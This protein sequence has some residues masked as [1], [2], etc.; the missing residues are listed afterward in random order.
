[1]VVPKRD[2]ANMFFYFTINPLISLQDQFT[3]I[4]IDI[5]VYTPKDQSSI[6]NINSS[7]EL[8]VHSNASSITYVNHIQA[9]ANC[10]LWAEQVE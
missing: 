9:I 10:S 1:M 3:T 8:L 4:P 2:L 6:Y 7:K 5:K